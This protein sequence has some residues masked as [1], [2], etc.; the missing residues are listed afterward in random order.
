MN[1]FFR[2]V[3]DVDLWLG[4]LAERHM[5]GSVVGPTFACLISIQFYHWKYGDRFYFE[6]GG[7]DGSF[8]LGIRGNYIVFYANLHLYQ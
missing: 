5:K 3:S 7:Q 6:H 4:G 2:N 8:T 1:D